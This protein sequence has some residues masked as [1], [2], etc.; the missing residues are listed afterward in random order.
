MDC[1]LEPRHPLGAAAGVGPKL[2]GCRQRRAPP[3]RVVPGV[4]GTRSAR[5]GESVVRPAHRA[6]SPPAL[7]LSGC[8]PLPS[9]LVSDGSG[10]SLLPRRR[11]SAIP[12]L[13]RRHVL[14]RPQHPPASPRRVRTAVSRTHVSPSRGAAR[15]CALPCH[16]LRRR[17]R[18]RQ[19]ARHRGRHRAAGPKPAL[20]P[21]AAREPRL[22]AAAV[23]VG[24]QAPES[25]AGALRHRRSAASLLVPLRVSEH[26]RHTQ[27]GCRARVQ[28][29]GSAVT[30]CVVRNL[31]RTPVPRGPSTHLRERGGRRRVRD[32]RVLESGRADRCRR[33]ARRQLDGSRRVQ[34]GR[35]AVAAG[36]GSGAWTER[37]V[38]TP[39]PGARRLAA[40]TSCAASPR[41]GRG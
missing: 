4:H 19:R 28:R 33:H 31:L 32:R 23:S 8:G 3:V 40:A 17:V 2:E 26:E 18:P 41:P 34:V 9:A 1:G 30:R 36:D 11:P 14:H 22:P 12:A 15:N 16:S 37:R 29:A 39:T 7:R 25:E 5:Q 38:C 6:D 27:R 13:S 35:R 10:E 20:L 21:S 24:G